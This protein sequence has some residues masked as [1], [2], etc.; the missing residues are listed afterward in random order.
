MPRHEA[1]YPPAPG[2]S[3]H[4]SVGECNISVHTPENILEPSNC[5]DDESPLLLGSE[6]N[7][8]NSSIRGKLIDRFMYVVEC[9]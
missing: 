7:G 9:Y 6:E 5:D 4:H 8:T 3:L 1:P 2:D